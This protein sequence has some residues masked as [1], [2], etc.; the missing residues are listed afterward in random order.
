ML[1]QAG[2]S[3]V[4]SVQDQQLAI[5]KDG[6]RTETYPVST[7]KFGVGDRPRSYSTPLGTMQIAAKI[8][9]GAPMG[10]VFK[11][12]QRTGEILRPDSPGRDPIVTRILWLRGLETKNA[13]A[14][15]RGI[16][17]HGTA[18]ERKIGRPASYGCIRMRSRDVVRVFDSVPVGTRVEVINASLKNGLRGT[19]DDT[20]LSRRAG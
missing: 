7:S 12:R 20:R 8:G 1:A 14:Y 15:E 16:Y 5:V 17:I 9:S 18:E 10:A 2:T 6:C 4:V 11:N 3:V 13:R 19:S